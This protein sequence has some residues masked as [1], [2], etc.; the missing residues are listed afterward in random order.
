MYWAFL[1]I[2]ISMNVLCIYFNKPQAQRLALP[3]HRMVTKPMKIRIICV[4]RLKESYYSDA[5]N[6]FKK[7][8]SRYAETEILELA[9]G[10]APEKLSPAELNQ[11]KTVEC[12]RILDRI[13]DS[14]T[15][16]ALDIEGKQLSSTA[17][18]KLI[19]GYMLDGKS[20]LTF[21]IGG[22]NGLTP[23]VLNRADFR[24]SFS[25]LTFSHQIF[26]IMLME[27]LYR[28]FKILNNE[29]YHK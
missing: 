20:R 18:S 5:V 4:G 3:I 21:V 9:D 25:K 19:G 22:S 26:R 17:L 15:V 28:A 6:E 24:L 23:E 14:E 7:R 27:Q 2:H 29:P 8:L 10:K 12:R 11:V 16:I 13:Q 1:P